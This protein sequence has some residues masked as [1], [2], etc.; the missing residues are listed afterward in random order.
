MR[1]AAIPSVD[2]ILQDPRL[3]PAV[4]RHGR[5]LVV[6]ELR[7]LLEEYRGALKSGAALPP[8]GDGIVLAL[9]HRLDAGARLRCGACST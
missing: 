4:A 1:L 7:A 8:S 3:E 9:L 6:A 2:R 5:P